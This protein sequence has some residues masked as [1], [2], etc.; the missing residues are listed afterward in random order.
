MTNT[1]KTIRTIAVIALALAAVV[2]FSLPASAQSTGKDFTIGNKGE[3]HFN[4][5]VKAGG[6]L[7]P[8]GMYQL[9][10]QVEGV[11]HVVIF[12]EMEM[13]ANYRHS[14]TPVGKEVV[15]RIKC[16]VEPVDK[17]V[18]TTKIEL[19]TNAKGEKEVAEVQ[20]AGEAFKHIF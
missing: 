13:P 3:I 19:R 4:V 8:P 14:N 18:N 11:D 2:V 17:K 1:T 12:K 16:R 5:P 10:H 9:Q 15:A 7:L 20:V 6:T